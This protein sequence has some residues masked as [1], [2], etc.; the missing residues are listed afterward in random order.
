LTFLLRFGFLLGHEIVFVG[1]LFSF[2]IQEK[3]MA[4]TLKKFV[5]TNVGRSAKKYDWDNWL[6]GSAWELEKGKDFDIE[7][8]SFRCGAYLAAGRRG[9]RLQTSQNGD[10][11]VIMATPVE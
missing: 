5:F 10:K 11:I 9:K 3:E 4:K 8:S 1:I 2:T 7:V 6:N